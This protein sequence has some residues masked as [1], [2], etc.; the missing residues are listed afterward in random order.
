[1]QGANRFQALDS[2]RGLFALAV[3]TYHIGL[4]GSFTELAFFRNADLFVEFFFVLSGFVLAH[5][6]GS[7]ER[8]DFSRFFITRSL[9]LFP[10]HWVMLL[11]FIALEVGKAIAWRKGLAF[12][13]KPFSGAT[14]LSEILP[15]ALLVQSWTGFTEALSFNYPAWSISVEYYMYMV[16]LAA[17][18]LRGSARLWGWAAI[19]ALAALALYL[20]LGGLTPKALRGLLCFFGGALAYMAYRRLSTRIRAGFACFTG[21]ELLSVAL[22]VAL[23]ISS[24]DNKMP[25]ARVLF[26]AVV[27]VY[28]FDG[29]AVSRLLQGR[30]FHLIGKVSYSIYMTHAAVWFCVVSCFMVLQKLTGT[31]FAPSIGPKRYV[32]TGS[33]LLNNLLAVAVLLMVVG[34]A[35]LTYRYVELKGQQLGARLAQRAPSKG[36]TEVGVQERGA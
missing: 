31:P 19:A 5:A 21:L 14:A 20:E 35:M 17:L 26:C 6:Y 9:R 12:N 22:V 27:V 32:D 23:L 16:F 1:M 4:P 33:V 18:L 24:L 2:F 11:V 30:V 10:L 7:K 3:V 34:L 28:A 29:G 25:L 36:A 8:V 13:S 15:N